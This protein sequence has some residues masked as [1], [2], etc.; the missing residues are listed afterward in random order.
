MTKSQITHPSFISY[1]PFKDQ[2][3]DPSSSD[4]L[5]IHEEVRGALHDAVA[6]AKELIGPVETKELNE[7]ALLVAQMVRDGAIHHA[8]DDEKEDGQRDYKLGGE[9]DYL[10]AYLTHVDHDQPFEQWPALFGVLTLSL[11]GE[12]INLLWPSDAYK[13][14]CNPKG[15]SAD[16]LP[17]IPNCSATIRMTG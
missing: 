15:S 3:I 9:P 2:R 11:A 10:K 6:R 8:L 1:D 13:N 7:R 5:F 14:W 17:E 4:G 16:S 12:L